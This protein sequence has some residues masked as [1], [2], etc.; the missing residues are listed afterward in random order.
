MKYEAINSTGSDF[1]ANGST[2]LGMWGLHKATVQKVDLN[3]WERANVGYLGRMSY[4]YNEKYYFT[5]SYRRDGA[6]VFGAQNKWADFAAA[7]AAWKISKENFMS[8]VTVLDDLKLKLS[9]GQNGNQGIGPYTTLSQ[10]ANGSSGGIRY[11]FSD[12]N[13]IV[14]YGL[15]QSTLGNQELGWESTNS[16][17]TGFESAWLKN[18]LFVDVDIYH[19]KTTDQI[20]TRNI[21]VMTGFKT[22]FASMGQINNTGIEATVR[23]INIQTND[24]T[25]STMVTFWKN[26]NKLVELYGED[27]DGDGIEDDDIANSLFIGKS[28]GAIYG[29]K[30]IGIVQESDTEYIKLTGVAPGAPKYQDMDNEPGITADDRSILGY[31]KENF[32][33]NMSNTVSYKKLELY[34]MISGIFG[35]NDH[36]LQNNT[37]AYLTS[38][39]G[40][41]NANMTSKPYWTPENQSNEYPSATFAGDGRFRGLQSRGFVRI[42]DITLSYTFDQSWVKEANI[43]TLKLFFAAK[44]IATFTPWDGGDPETGATYLS[45]TFPVV[46]TYSIGATISF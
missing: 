2:T 14:Q 1:A 4:S 35:G 7:G 41:F 33:L 17:N 10:V 6:S 16:W 20:F 18:R 39:T 40:L 12:K 43:S 29:Y 36:Y 11:E 44:N 3:A 23:S 22:V 13:G 38:G 19:S 25:W 26:N 45:N 24:L 15:I 8:N 5:G 42:Q 28:L 37:Q 32:R 21:P 30:Q 27:N 9:W 31:S 46:S 34:A